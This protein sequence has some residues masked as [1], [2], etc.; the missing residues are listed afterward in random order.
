MWKICISFSAPV[1]NLEKGEY[2]HEASERSARGLGP[3]GRPWG[4]QCWRQELL[5]ALPDAGKQ[6]LRQRRMGWS[7][8]LVQQRLREPRP[9][10]SD[11]NALL[12][13]G[14]RS[15][16]ADVAKPLRHLGQ[17]GLCHVHPHDLSLQ[18]A[19][20]ADG[21]TGWK[22]IDES[23]WQARRVSADRAGHPI[24]VFEAGPDEVPPSPWHPLT[25][26]LVDRAASAATRRTDTADLQ[27]KLANFAQ[28]QGLVRPPAVKWFANP[29]DAVA[30]LSRMDLDV[31]LAMGVTRF[32]RVDEPCPRHPDRDI[33]ATCR[34]RTIA[35]G[36]VDVTELIRL[37][38]N[39][40]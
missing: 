23:S 14:R 25:E 35:E 3:I 12:N 4:P 39:R 28:A 17:G 33:D 9:F 15:P 7:S 29:A 6:T 38:C 27:S 1:N 2:R 30:H 21:R 24:G 36:L 19:S 26:S 8:K 34:L 5:P 18:A 20:P 22:S 10:P 37:T 13:I 16:R 32:W 40:N 31:L 11:A